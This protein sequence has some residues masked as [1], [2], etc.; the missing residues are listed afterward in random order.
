MENS[1]KTVK[2]EWLYFI[3]I[4]WIIDLLLTIL[5]LGISLFIYFNKNDFKIINM[6]Y[7]NY[8]EAMLLEIAIPY[9]IQPIGIIA[10]FLANLCF[11][12]QKKRLFNSAILF[13]IIIFHVFLAFVPHELIPPYIFPVIKNILNILF[14]G[15]TSINFIFYNKFKNSNI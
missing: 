1:E 8:A 12:I 15:F 11:K 4:I 10:L 6:I 3:I 9:V 13:F 7:L 14:I 5:N 2:D